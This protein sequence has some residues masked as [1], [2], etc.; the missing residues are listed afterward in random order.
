[1]GLLQA[2]S[3]TLGLKTLACALEQ[4]DLNQGGEGF[5]A[6]LSQTRSENVV[7]IV[8][9]KSG[10]SPVYLEYA[11]AFPGGSDLISSY[12]LMAQ[13]NRNIVWQKVRVN[14]LGVFFFLCALVVMLSV[15]VDLKSIFR[16]ERSTNQHSRNRFADTYFFTVNCDVKVLCYELPRGL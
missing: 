11:K 1:M 4:F 7:M 13:A 10:E 8:K 5:C 15:F 12:K 16:R 14:N 3:T 9:T 6:D 2:C